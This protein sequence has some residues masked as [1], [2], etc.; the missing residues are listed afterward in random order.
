MFIIAFEACRKLVLPICLWSAKRFFLCRTHTLFT[1]Y[2]Q[3][4]T[5]HLTE[6]LVS[7][8][9]GTTID[10]IVIFYMKTVYYP[11]EKEFGRGVAGRWFWGY[12]GNAAYFAMELRHEEKPY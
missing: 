6:P 1:F 3:Q 12:S 2:I 8:K 7:F 4:I 5:N 11:D 9:I 10:L